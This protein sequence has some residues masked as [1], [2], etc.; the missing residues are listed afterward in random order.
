M[1]KSTST[2]KTKQHA[3]NCSLAFRDCT[4]VHIA[5]VGERSGDGVLRDV[6]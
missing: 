3:A 2:K 5:R 6:T 4:V 1:C